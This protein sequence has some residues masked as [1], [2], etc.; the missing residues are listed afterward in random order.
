[1]F[2]PYG[3]ERKERMRRLRFAAAL[4][5]ALDSEFTPEAVA[6]RYRAR[7]RMAADP[8]LN[9]VFAS[10]MIGPEILPGEVFSEATWERIL[11]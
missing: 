5:S 1:M 11:A 10:V 6:R 4:Q 7:E 9:L 3:E 8:S 2:A